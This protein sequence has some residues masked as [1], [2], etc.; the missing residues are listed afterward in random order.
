MQ[1][2]L[3]YS[4][5]T[6]A[7]RNRDTFSKWMYSFRRHVSSSLGKAPTKTYETSKKF[8][9]I[10]RSRDDIPNQNKCTVHII[11]LEEACAPVVIKRSC[12]DRLTK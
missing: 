8:Y 6:A 10:L 3:P 9:D 2:Y 5:L 1:K 12:V 4:R 11:P 7:L